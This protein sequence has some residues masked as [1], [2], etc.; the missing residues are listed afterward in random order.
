MH[1]D[2]HQHFWIYDSS[3]YAWIDESMASLRRNCLPKDLKPELD[4]AGF[5][6]CVA[7]QARQTSEET[8]WLL[9][10][11]AES[12]FILGVVGWLDLRS[13]HLRSELQA[14]VNQPKLVG[15]RHIVQSEPDDRFLLQPEFLR[16]VS[17]LEEYDLTYDILIYEK[18]LPVVIAFVKEFPKQRFVL[19]HLAKPRIK[20]GLMHPWAEGIRELAT[21][22]NV[23]CKLSGLVTEADWQKWRPEELSPYLEVAMECFGADRLMIGSDW[24]VCTVAASYSRVM[25]TINRY[26]EPFSAEIREKLLGENATNFYRLKNISSES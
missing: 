5:Q 24:P 13:P 15:L 8:K 18:H 7:V 2:A 9:Q 16:G 26:L 6:G 19:D 25:D 3:E 11:A 4:R 23:C 1:I 17:R 21:F 10:L 14:F 20:E 12:P 22:P